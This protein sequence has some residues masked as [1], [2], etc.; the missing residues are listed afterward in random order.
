M[1]Y[2]LDLF[3]PETYEAFTRSDRM[4]SGFRA[5]QRRA[6]SRVKVGDKLICYMT[7][8]SRWIGVL[9]V[10]SKWYEDDSPIFYAQDDPFVIRFRVKPLAWLEKEKAIPIREDRVWEGLTFTRGLNK[11]SHTWTG[12]LRSSLN[13]L[14]DSDGHFLEQFIMAQV[15]AGQVFPIDDR[16]YER[17]ITHRVRRLDKVVTVSVP[18]DTDLDL[19]E[20]P[21]GHPEVRESIRIQALLASIGA[22]MGMRIW[23]PRSDRSAVLGE[24]RSDDRPVLEVLPS[25]L[26]SYGSKAEQL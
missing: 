5:R 1:T 3:S 14:T 12:K 6:A 18:R 24:C 15:S 25:R 21:E 20:L 17:L 19:A 4:V 10:L 16:E 9:E 7:R 13:R 23:I 26:T 8:L 2:F 11:S 22:K